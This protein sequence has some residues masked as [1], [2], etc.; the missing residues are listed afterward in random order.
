MDAA[1]GTRTA[2]APRE[3]QMRSLRSR[4]AGL[5]AA[6]GLLAAAGSAG[7]AESIDI[8]NYR[9]PDREQRLLAGARAEGQVFIYSTVIVSQALRPLAEAFM[10]IYPFV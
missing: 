3:E 7:A 9:G 5:A 6:A 10:M 1:S 8:L 4:V 2:G